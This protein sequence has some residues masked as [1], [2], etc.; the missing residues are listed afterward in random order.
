[1]TRNSGAPKGA[2][3]AALVLRAALGVT[4]VAHG[5]QKIFVLGWDGA[6]NFGEWGIPLSGL[7]YPLVVLVEAGGGLALIL[8]VWVRPMA[9]ALGAVM[10]G[11]LLVVH[12]P[13]GFFLPYGVEFV[14]VLA[15][16]S[17]ALVL[18]G[19]GRWALGRRSQRR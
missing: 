19:P 2:E 9:A 15:A 5:L 16:A 3:W 18:L 8:G 1:M 6:A 13:H 11:A 4:F 17:G 12:L 14:F 7:T 10:I